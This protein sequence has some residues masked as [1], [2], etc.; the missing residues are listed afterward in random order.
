MNIEVEQLEFEQDSIH[1]TRTVRENDVHC[2]RPYYI[3]KVMMRSRNNGRAKDSNN[4]ARLADEGGGDVIGK[5]VR[6]INYKEPNGY[7]IARDQLE[8]T[9]LKF[10]S[11][12]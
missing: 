8:Q 7:G 10:V 2:V 5:C 11:I 3:V 12:V 4:S 1:R 9:S 6:G